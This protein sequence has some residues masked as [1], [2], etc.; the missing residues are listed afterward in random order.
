VHYELPREPPLQ[1]IDFTV[2]GFYSAFTERSTAGVKMMRRKVLSTAIIAMAMGLIAAAQAV[3]TVTEWETI[4][5]AKKHPQNWITHH[6]SLDGQRFSRLEQINKQNVKDLKVAFTH[7]VGGA[8]GAGVWEHAGLEGTPLA[9]DGY[10]YITDGWGSVYKLDVRQNGKLVWKMDPETDREWAAGVT[11]C[12]VDNRGVAL[13]RDKVISHSLDGRLI[14]TNKETGEIEK[15][16]PVAD[17]AISETLTVAPLVIKDKVITGVSGADYGIRGWLNATDL[18][19]GERDWRTH[20]IPAPGEPGSETWKPGPEAHSVDA[21]KHGGGSTWVNGSYDP[22]LN[23]VYWGV[24]NP[25]P[26]WDNAYRPGDNLYT[27]SVLALDG[28]TGAIKWHFQYIPNDPYDYDG[29]NEQTLA[30]ANVYGKMTKVVLHANRNGF[31]YALDR[32]NGKFLWGTPFVKKLDWTAGLDKYTG[33]PVDYDPNSDVQRYNPA[34]SVSRD[35]RESTSCPGNMGGKNWP[36]TAYDPERNRYYIPVIE[37]CSGHVNVPTEEPWKPREYFL[38][39][40]PKMGPVITGSVTAMDVNTGKVAGK[41]ETTYPM[42]GGLLATKGGLI[43]GGQPD[44]RVFAIDSDSMEEL[45]S[46]STNTAINAP[47]ISFEVDGKQYIALLAGKGGA[48]PLWFISATPALTEM[49]AGQVLF[50]F[51]L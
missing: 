16:I 19:A 22:D 13:W 50:V 48:W 27:N 36:P 38:G 43:F 26:D 4:V 12:G 35:Q 28:D 11:C 17:P 30:D 49:E 34:S 33:R 37:S 23:T 40:A 51:S 42:Y 32:T 25:A 1:S 8:G 9:E 46:F 3:E 39:G 20:T 31:A 47:P 18:V 15:E 2:Q 24:G 41:Y 29:V 5:N 6:G 45:W 14:I 7:I 44:G 10:L 21:W